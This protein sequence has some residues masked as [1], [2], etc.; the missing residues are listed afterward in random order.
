ML[1]LIWTPSRDGGHQATPPDQYTQVLRI[2][3]QSSGYTVR[4]QES[5][6]TVKTAF[7]YHDLYSAQLAA[8]RMAFEAGWIEQD[9]SML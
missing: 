9:P 2:Y 5:G 7:P 1:M 3:R 6:S 4:L 8:E